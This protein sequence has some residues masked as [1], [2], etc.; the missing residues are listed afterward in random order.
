MI[1]DLGSADNLRTASQTKCLLVPLNSLKR[2]LFLSSGQAVDRETEDRIY[3]ME[4]DVQRLNRGLETLRGTVNGLEESLRASLREDANRMLSALLSASPGAVPAPAAASAQSTVG[5]VEISLGGP[6][7]EGLDGRTV[8]PG[9]TELNGRVEELR[10]VLQAKT[11]ELQELKA[12]VTGHDGALK[13]MAAG[14]ISD[15]AVSLE[16]APQIAI[17][18]LMDGKLSEARSEILGGFEVRVKSAEGRCEEKAGDLRRQCQREQSERQEQMEDALEGSSTDLRSELRDLQAQIQGLKASGNCSGSVGGLVERVHRLETSVV[19][20]NQSQGHLRVELGGHKDHIEGMLE[21][22]LGY[23][24][25]KLNVTGEVQYNGSERGS[26]FPEE[27]QGVEEARMEGRLLALEERLLMALEE[28][29]N[30]TLPP[31]H[32]PALETEMDSIRERLEVD[33]D[34]LQRRLSSLETR[35]TSSSTKTPS[36]LQGDSAASP[37]EEQNV[38]DALDMQGDGLRRLNVTLQNV[39]K[40]LHRQEQAEGV[41]PVQAEL[42]ILKCNVRSVNHTLKDLQETLGTVVHQ[43]GQANSSWQMSEASL[44]KQIKG[45]VQLVGHQAAMLGAGERR[46]TRV[47]GE[48]QGMRRRLAEE[49]RGCRSTAMGVRKEVTEVGGRVTSVEDQCKGLSYLAEDLERIREELERQSS[50]LLVQVNGTLSSHAQQLSEL[51]GEVRNC[52]A[53]LDPTQHS[54]EPEPGRGDTFALN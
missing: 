41:N 22:R 42:T 24:E 3:R 39:L 7:A 19:G 30:S 5:F 52:T 45:V 43:V 47:K 29:V 14:I 50:G 44:A 25:A 4:E 34:R 10:T 36:A 13:K 48:L 35:C 15:S 20:L 17:E 21:G 11:L 40:R 54:S 38:K 51:R 23:V 27:G 32:G 28:P 46:L 33:V 16:G 26:V 37:S 18:N 12:T 2:L 31:L 8:F 1:R 49:V 6:E 9:L 53:Q